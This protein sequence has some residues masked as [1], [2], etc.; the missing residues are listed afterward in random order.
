VN[1]NYLVLRGIYKNYLDVE[2]PKEDDEH[3]G[4]PD[5]GRELY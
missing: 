5:S 4:G 3:L 2:I 1:V